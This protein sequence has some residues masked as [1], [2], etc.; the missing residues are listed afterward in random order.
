MYF[1][2]SATS[3][4]FVCLDHPVFHIAARPSF[5][6]DDLVSGS[7]GPERLAR[8]R[9]TSRGTVDDCAERQRPTRSSA[10]AI[11]ANPRLLFS[12]TLQETV[13]TVPTR[14]QTLNRLSYA[15]QNVV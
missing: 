15:T 12:R 3:Q 8:D 10:Y 2:L 14:N 13:K 7:R 11:D 6:F 1:A 4:V 9:V 5:D